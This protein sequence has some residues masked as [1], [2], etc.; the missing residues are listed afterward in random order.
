MT[1]CNIVF[2]KSNS[3]FFVKKG[4]I[5]LVSSCL[6]VHIAENCCAFVERGH[7]VIFDYDSEYSTR[8]VNL[9]SLSKYALKIN[10][11]TCVQYHKS[12]FVFRDIISFEDY[13][14]TKILNLLCRACAMN[15]DFKEQITWYKCCND[16]FFRVKNYVLTNIYSELSLDDIANNLSESK[17]Q[18]IRI[19]NKY[20]GI[21]PQ[22]WINL[23]KIN[24]AWLLVN[25]TDKSVLQ[26]SE[27]LGYSQSSYL[28]ANYKKIF[29]LTPL[30]SRKLKLKEKMYE[31]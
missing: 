5:V 13:K 22:K 14:N 2:V 24:Y 11:S 23:Q 4:K 8:N 1:D 17:F 12:V 31:F 25:F 16:L 27:I 6:T 15:S 29:G 10:S 28:V 20:I 26:I 30:S 9:D 21:T 19:F 7:Y 3:F 18:I